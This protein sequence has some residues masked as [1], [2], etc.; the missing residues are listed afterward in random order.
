MATI[1][2]NEAEFLNQ[3]LDRLSDPFHLSYRFI[4]FRELVT[5]D[6]DRVF[7]AQLGLGLKELRILRLAFQFPGEPVSIIAR[8]TFS[9]KAM[10][11]KLVSRLCGLGYLERRIDEADARSTQL[12]VTK[13]GAALVKKADALSNELFRKQLP[14][15]SSDATAQ[16][17]K[18]LDDVLKGFVAAQ[19]TP[20]A[21]TGR[22]KAVRAKVR[23]KT[24]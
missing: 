20:P 10:M 23:G 7:K 1:R 6:N 12:F 13:S 11:S 8:W 21:G 14:M 19:M 3:V 15:L 5:N 22:G 16:L 17:M 2:K 4:A 24:E 18:T 9:E